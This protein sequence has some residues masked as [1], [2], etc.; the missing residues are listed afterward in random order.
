MHVL[1][2]LHVHL[3]YDKNHFQNVVEVTRIL[4][5]ARGITMNVLERSFLDTKTLT[6]NMFSSVSIHQSIA[7]EMRVTLSVHYLHHFLSILC[8]YNVT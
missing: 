5:K 8:M 1:M 3:L 7:A 4:H 6:V 2:T